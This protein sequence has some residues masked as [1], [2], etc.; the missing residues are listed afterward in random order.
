[1]LRARLLGSTCLAF[2]A[3]AST[4]D[5][6]VEI[7]RLV[8]SPQTLIVPVGGDAPTL[9][10]EAFGPAGEPL[11]L[12][13]DIS[14]SSSEI[15]TVGPTF[16]VSAVGG[17][18][19]TQLVASAAGVASDPV[20]IV[21]AEPADGAILLP[22][23]SFLSAVEVVGEYPAD[24]ELPWQ[25]Q[26]ILSEDHPVQT[27]VM[28]QG[29]TTFGGRIIS[30][31]AAAGGGFTTIVESVPL[32]SLFK[33]L[34]ISASRKLILTSS[35][36]AALSSTRGALFGR[37]ARPVS[38][39]PLECEVA[40]DVA[41]TNLEFN[42]V[43]RHDVSNLNAN[44]TLQVQDG[45]TTQYEALVE[46][47]LSVGLVG[48][49][50]IPLS[51]TSGID[52]RVKVV[53]APIFSPG[54]VFG[55]VSVEAY[56]ALGVGF[57]GVASTVTSRINLDGDLYGD[58]RVGFTFDLATESLEFV[59]DGDF[60]DQ[61]KVAFEYEGGLGSSIATV[62]PKVSAGIGTQAVL[63]AG[64]AR[65]IYEIAE[66]KATIEREL[67]FGTIDSQIQ[68]TNFAA[69]ETRDL[70]LSFTIKQ[71]GLAL[72]FG[73]LPGIMP[74]LEQVLGII[75]AELQVAVNLLSGVGIPLPD[76]VFSL[77]RSPQGTLT[78]PS[79][80]MLGESAEMTVE[81]TDV[82]GLGGYNVAEVQIFE[83]SGTGPGFISELV[84]SLPASD[85]QTTFV[86]NFD[87]SQQGVG[88]QTYSAFVITIQSPLTPYEIAADSRKTIEVTEEMTSVPAVSF[89]SFDYN[90]ATRATCSTAVYAGSNRE[91]RDYGDDVMPHTTGTD[92]MT[93][94]MLGCSKTDSTG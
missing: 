2:V 41:L 60:D 88:S 52:C 74:V 8:V 42:V 47:P 5:D 69:S 90:T 44:F 7:S 77:G 33:N 66:A 65:Q 21:V 55:L 1:M 37:T 38:L 59:R 45:I 67:S 49:I 83:H 4:A 76:N 12:P 70:T 72:M 6:S 81:L 29:G 27:L 9:H 34:D 73:W 31:T 28:A 25:M 86:W 54:G 35:Q 87:S 63:G 30:T 85:G 10:V 17:I 11:P 56:I 39:G 68:N 61:V 58:V 89:L 40:S 20:Q 84:A 15:I 82:D 18:G 23:S 26:A 57:K 24:P 91:S 79:Q 36:S 14:W 92:S 50:A 13:S 80:V 94:R 51:F 3:C 48:N 64:S 19:S 16:A 46:G 53:E 78:G 43:P 93:N 62:T 22:D 71:L 75:L 32:P